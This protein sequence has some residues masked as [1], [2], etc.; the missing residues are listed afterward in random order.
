MDPQPIV[1]IVD[2]DPDSRL[3]LVAIAKSLRVDVVAFPNAEEFLAAYNENATCCLVTDLRMRGMSGLDLLRHLKAAGLTI[4]TVIVTGY[5]ETA[6]AVDAMRAGAVTFLEKTV[7]QHKICE[8]I[9]QALAQSSELLAKKAEL[10]RVKQIWGSFN[11]EER[12]VL[13]MVAQGKLNKEIAFETGAPLRTI[14]DRR[15]RL[16][17]KLGASSVVDLVRFAILLEELERSGTSP[18]KPDA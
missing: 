10:D 13:T 11:L 8:A 6:I 7:P 2:D 18:K 17:T 9:S 4:P 16:M 12:Q 3:A 15:R 1:Y 5:A 14:E